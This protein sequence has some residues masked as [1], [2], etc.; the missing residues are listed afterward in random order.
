M[1]CIL[2]SKSSKD[3]NAYRD[4]D[5]I[6][7]TGFPQY[8]YEWFH[9]QEA[10][11]HPRHKHADIERWAFYYGVKALARE[12]AEAKVFW[13]L[14]DETHGD[15]GAFFLLQ[16]LRIIFLNCSAYIKPQLGIDPSPSR[17]S[18]VNC[19]PSQPIDRWKISDV[20]WISTNAAKSASKQVLHKVRSFVM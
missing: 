11:V 19:L 12:N 3:A 16:S 7:R 14:M 20:I 10:S 15:D 2:W 9:P 17:I 4:T 18:S 13:H 1:R 5:T 8:V 6:L